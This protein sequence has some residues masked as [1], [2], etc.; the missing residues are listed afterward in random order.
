[1]IHLK[2]NE[3]VIF[4]PANEVFSFIEDFRNFNHLMPQQ[5]QNYK[6]DRDH[7]SFDISSMGHVSL[8][9]TERVADSHVKASSTGQTPVKFDLLVYLEAVKTQQCTA[10]IHLNAELSPMFAMLARTPL[11]NFIN[12]MAEKLKEVLEAPNSK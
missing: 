8:E 1:M 7:C 11:T 5:V 3:Q 6:A 2:S 12:M 9:M 10:T 4:R